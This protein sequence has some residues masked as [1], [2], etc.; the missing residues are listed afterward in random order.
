MGLPICSAPESICRVGTVVAAG[1]RCFQNQCA[2]CPI[3][4]YG[5]N[6]ISCVNCPPATWS[7][8]SGSTFCNTTFT[9]TVAG[10]QSFQIPQSVT[11]VNVKLWGAGGGGHSRIAGRD[12]KPSSGGGGGYASCNLTVTPSSIIYFIVGGGGGSL[13]YLSGAGGV[14]KFR[15]KTVSFSNRRCW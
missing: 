2:P 15:R 8:S 7:P 6:G 13:V 1:Y 9:S 12:L 10:L 14:Y 5:T 11:K 3:G 4:T